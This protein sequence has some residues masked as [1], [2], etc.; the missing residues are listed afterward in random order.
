MSSTQTTWRFSRAHPCWRASLPA[1]AE[2]ITDLPEA[3]QRLR[4]LSKHSLL[5]QEL[6]ADEPTYRYHNLLREFLAARIGDA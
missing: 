1:I 2:A 4:K 6:A 5:V 3:G